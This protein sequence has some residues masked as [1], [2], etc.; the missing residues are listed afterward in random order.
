[1]HNDQYDIDD[2]G[3]GIDVAL[4]LHAVDEQPATVQAVSDRLAKHVADLHRARVRHRHLRRRHREG[5]RAGRGRRRRPRVVRR[6]GPGRPAREDRGR[7][8]PRGGPDPGRARPRGAPARSTTRT[9]SARRTPSRASPRPTARRP[10]RRRTFLLA[11]Q[12]SGGWFRLDFTQGRD[13]RGPVLRRGPVQQAATSTPPPSRVRALGADDSAPVAEARDSAL[14]WL[15]QQQ[16][17]DGSFGGGRPPGRPTPTARAWPAPRWARPA[18]RRRPSGRR[19][20]CSRHQAVDCRSFPPAVRGAIAYDDAG[21]ATAA[22]QGHQ[23]QGRRPVPSGQRRRAPG[24]AVAADEGD[25]RPV[26]RVLLR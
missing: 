9:S 12:C 24:A 20:G 25:R 13:V 26:G 16:A 4:A 21:L 23:R 19:P 14:A 10:A 18:T 3:L 15:K 11:Q 5:G 17:K 8:R 6:H 7:P 2:Y 1:M 22:Q